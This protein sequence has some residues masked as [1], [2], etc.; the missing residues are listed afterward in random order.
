MSVAQARRLW[1]ADRAKPQPSTRFV[2]SRT[3][4]DYSG[5][6][7]PGARHLSLGELA[8]RGAADPLPGSGKIVVYG[9]DPGSPAAMGL[10]KRLIALGCDDVYLLQGGLLSWRTNGGEL[11]K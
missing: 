7:I 3:I 1:V 8:Q 4:E 6:H 11:E 5:G 10:A 9:A 2:D